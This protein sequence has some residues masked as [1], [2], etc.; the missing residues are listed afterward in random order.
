MSLLCYEGFPELQRAGTTLCCGVQA[1]YCCNLSC[2]GAWALGHQA[3]VIVAHGLSSCGSWALEHRLNSCGTWALLLCSMWDLPAPGI[4][5]VSPA[6]AGGFLSPAPLGTSVMDACTRPIS[7]SFS[8]IRFLWNYCV[9]HTLPPPHFCLWLALP[10][11]YFYSC[12][13]CFSQHHLSSYLYVLLCSSIIAGYILPPPSPSIN[14][15]LL[16]DSDHASSSFLE[17]CGMRPSK[18]ETWMP[19]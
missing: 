1:S 2:C 16:K 17:P 6:L 8:R 10:F 13:F 9:V 15:R 14:C 7:L 19:W 5:P 12:L 3:S 11:K 18:E 4:E